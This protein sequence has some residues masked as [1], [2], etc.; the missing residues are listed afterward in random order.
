MSATAERPFIL[1]VVSR[2]ELCGDARYAAEILRRL[3]RSRFRLAAVSLERPGRVGLELQGAEVPVHTID[4]P[5][6]AVRKR[7]WWRFVGLAQLHSYMRKLKPDLVHTV[8]FDGSLLGRIAARMAGVPRVVTTLRSPADERGGAAVLARL[9][10]GAADR[11]ICLGPSMSDLARRRW[12][13][14]P[15]RLVFMDP[16]TDVLRAA[17][18]PPAEDLEGEGPLLGAMGTLHRRKGYDVLIQ[19]L[20]MLRRFHPRIRL[21][22]AGLGPE[23]R[24]LQAQA[25]R[26]GVG[27]ALILPGERKHPGPFLSAI[28]VFVAPSRRDGVPLALLEAAAAERPIVA[29]DVPGIRDFIDDDV[30]GLLVPKEQP[31]LLADAIDR[32]LLEPG[33]AARLAAAARARAL[34][35]HTLPQLFDRHLQ[36]YETLLAET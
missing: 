16:A 12:N 33:L 26:A 30:H 20:V 9:T 32:L 25:A 34:A 19:A 21:M 22:I 15:R 5:E 17:G 27:E 11:T 36:L 24:A 7:P 18:W 28:D 3:D 35:H 14:H 8:G 6:S 10:A 31:A 4:L 2:T 13:L 29:S 1:F 23:G